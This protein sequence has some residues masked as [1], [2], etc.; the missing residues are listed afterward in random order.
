MLEAGKGLLVLLAGIG[1]LSFIHED[2][3]ALAERL[4]G[5]LHLNPASEYPR[6]FIEM[7]AR[8]NGTRLATLAMLAACYA[9]LRLIEAYGL[10]R[11]RRWAEWL[12]ALSGGVYIPFE[13]VEV[14]RGDLLLSL[15]ALVVNVVVVGVMVNALYR[16][17]AARAARTG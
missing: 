4:V 7:A 11:S 15:V 16:G 9:L 17:P 5:H 10:W 8:L 12:A 2:L 13:L 6:I 1:A 14:F 3:Q